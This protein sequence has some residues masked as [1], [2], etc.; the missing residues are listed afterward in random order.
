MKTVFALF[1]HPAEASEAVNALLELGYTRDDFSVIA[2][3]EVVPRQ[4]MATADSVAD[5]AASG[6]ALGGLAGLLVGIG[7]LTIPGF[8]PLIAA[9]PLVAALST[10][11]G[12][13]AGGLLG[14]LVDWGITEPEAKVYADAVRQGQILVAVATAVQHVDEV[15]GVL[16]DVGATAVT[17]YAHERSRQRV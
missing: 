8:G 15:V 17:V 10:A 16:E 7:A 3:E 13:T 5:G 2:K 9:G 14:A 4:D 1:E 6:A 11:A 12:A